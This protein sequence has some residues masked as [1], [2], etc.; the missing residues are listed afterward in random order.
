MRPETRTDH[1]LVADCARRD[2]NALAALYDR[3]G[4]VAYSIALRVVRDPGLAE[5]A[6]QEAFLAVWKQ[7]ATYDAK[8]AKPSTWILT[9]VHRRAVDHVRRN[10][11][12]G[13]IAQ[14]V[15]TFE[16][17]GI[18]EGVDETAGIRESRRSV[19]QAL[20]TL[21][22]AERR[23]LEL[24]YWAG[25]SQSEIATELGIPAGTVKSRTFTALARLRAALEA[26]EQTLEAP[27]QTPEPLEQTPELVAA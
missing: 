19:Q 15:A 5:D 10:V 11:R 18:V 21:P 9:I 17:P 7:A 16:A 3:H 12:H 23:V 6:V 13:E 1:E 26:P 8:L 2:E 14:R 25:L 27:R 20:A 4:K 22:A 24:A